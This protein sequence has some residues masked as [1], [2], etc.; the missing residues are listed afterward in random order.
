MPPIELTPAECAEV[1]QVSGM[2]Y[3]TCPLPPWDSKPMIGRLT[4]WPEAR[5]MLLRSVSLKCYLHPGCGSPA[6]GRWAVSDNQLLRWLFSGVC[7]EGATKHRK[8][9]LRLLHAAAWQPIFDEGIAPPPATAEGSAAS[10]SS[11]ALP[12]PPSAAI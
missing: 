1:A 4:S 6:K 5:P 12:L 9:E 10:S 11:D 7:E 8:H 3:I 2:G